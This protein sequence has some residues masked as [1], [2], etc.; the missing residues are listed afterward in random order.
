MPFVRIEWSPEK[1]DY[2]NHSSIDRLQYSPAGSKPFGTFE[3]IHQA[4]R[5]KPESVLRIFFT[6]EPSVVHPI[7]GAEADRVFEE[8]VGT[9]P[10]KA[11]E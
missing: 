6:S 8:L 11:T 9:P 4:A 1:V 2:H 10:P 7:Y 3:T 5:D